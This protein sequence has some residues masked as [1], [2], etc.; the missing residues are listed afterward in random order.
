MSLSTIFLGSS[1]NPAATHLANTDEVV[2]TKVADSPIY[3]YDG[4]EPLIR[5]TGTHPKVMLPRI[6][7]V[8]WQF[9]GDPLS[10]KW[11]WK[12]RFSN[13]LEQTTGWRPG[14]YRNY[15]LL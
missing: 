14:E 4:S 5:Y 3:T 7:A 11:S 1:K 15:K 9:Q 13:A 12:D 2:A 10:A 6:A 8:N